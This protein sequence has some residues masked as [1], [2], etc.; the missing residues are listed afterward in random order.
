MAIS[1]IGTDGLASSSVTSAKLASGAPS[2]AQLPAGTVLQVVQG[3]TTTGT[4]VASG[5]SFTATNLTASITP[6]SATNKIL[7]SYTGSLYVNAAA[8]EPHLT[9]YRN[10]SNIGGSQGISDLY[11]GSSG[12]IAGACGSILDSPATTSSTTYTVYMNNAIAGTATFP[13]NSTT[14]SITL[15]EVAV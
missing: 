12:I 3:T 13:V 14:A 7:V 5:A 2:R 6:T 10:A 1:T 9:I 8:G 15:M 11:N 4:S